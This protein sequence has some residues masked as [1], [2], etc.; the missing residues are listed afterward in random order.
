MT[1]VDGKVFVF[2][3]GVELDAIRQS[4]AQFAAH[5]GAQRV[6][7]QG[8]Q[9]DGVDGRPFV[10]RLQYQAADGPAGMWVLQC[11]EP[12]LFLHLLAPGAGA[13]LAASVVVA[14]DPP[15]LGF[16]GRGVEDHRLL[17]RHGFKGAAPPNNAALLDSE[18]A[19]D[20]GFVAG[21]VFVFEDVGRDMLTQLVPIQRVVGEAVQVVGGAVGHGV[22][23]DDV[24]GRARLTDRRSPVPRPAG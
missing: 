4:Q 2:V 20:R 23:E 22:E 18:A 21:A 15:Q 17:G 3:D 16:L 5:A 9:A 7:A 11:V 13:G 6:F 14:G 19:Q 10:A 8:R 24:G 1:Q 12:H